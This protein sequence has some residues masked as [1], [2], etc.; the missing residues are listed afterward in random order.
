MA[1]K[2]KRHT[3]MYYKAFHAGTLTSLS[4]RTKSPNFL[5]ACALPDCSHHQPKH[6]EFMMLGKATI[7]WKC[8][9]E[10]IIDLDMDKPMCLDCQGFGDMAREETLSQDPIMAE[11]MKRRKMRSER[12][13]SELKESAKEVERKRIQELLSKGFKFWCLGCGVPSVEVFCDPCIR[14]NTTEFLLDL[15]KENPGGNPMDPDN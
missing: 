1:T 15:I 14:T 8:K 5:W 11:I 3:H 13:Q 9:Q 6:Q 7:C 4:G 2:A 12:E 10:C